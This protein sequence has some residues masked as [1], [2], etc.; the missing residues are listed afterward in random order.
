MKNKYVTAFMHSLE[1]KHCVWKKIRFID[2]KMWEFQPCVLCMWFLWKYIFNPVVLVKVNGVFYKKMNLEVGD[3]NVDSKFYLRDKGRER[4]LSW[5]PGFVIL[6]KVW[7]LFTMLYS[8][9]SDVFGKKIG[10]ELLIN[11]V[12]NRQEAKDVIWFF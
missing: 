10:A 2:H 12:S 8:K 5:F 1:Y 4:P 6:Q 7:L 9:I 3:W 11:F